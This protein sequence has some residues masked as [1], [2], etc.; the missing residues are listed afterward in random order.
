MKLRNIG[1]AAGLKLGAIVTVAGLLVTQVAV[2]SIDWNDGAGGLTVIIS[3]FMYGILMLGGYALV[4]IGLA[5][6]LISVI[7]WAFAKY[8]STL[9]PEGK[10]R[11]QLVSLAVIGLAIAVALVTV[12]LV[13]LTAGHKLDK[14]VSTADPEQQIAEVHPEGPFTLFHENGQKMLEGRY[15]DNGLVQGP[16]TAWY[17]SGQKKFERDIADGKLV[18]KFGRRTDRFESFKGLNGRSVS[19]YENGELQSEELYTDYRLDGLNRWW[20]PDGKLQWERLHNDDGT[21][22]WKY[23]DRNGQQKLQFGFVDT[24]SDVTSAFPELWRR[25]ARSNNIKLDYILSN[26]EQQ[27]GVA[28]LFH[29]T[30]SAWYDKGHLGSQEGWVNGKKHGPEIHWASNG[31]KRLEK[32]FVDGK[33]HGTS[34][35]WWPNGQIQF[36]TM[37]ENG[38]MVDIAAYSTDGILIDPMT[39]MPIK[40]EDPN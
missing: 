31:R 15:D 19:W 3:F 23:F 5:L 12:V 1:L 30:W 9:D 25:I 8:Y 38:R 17:E 4:M 20:W 24:R 34:L 11:V 39:G 18:E 10:K 29:G 28:G 40:S 33:E 6:I 36:E 32:N 21:A 27:H 14:T 37:Y 13:D 7:G 22:T 26:G 16:V 2:P 35:K